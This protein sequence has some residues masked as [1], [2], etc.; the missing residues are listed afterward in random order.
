MS[1]IAR[2]S[3]AVANQIAA[4]EVVER[5]ASVVKELLEN[6]IDAG[7]RR[8]QVEIQAGGIDL[9]RITDDGCG[10][11]RDDAVLALER[12]ATSKIRA[13]EDLHS[14]T[15]LGFRGE[16]LPSIASVSR[17][18]LTTRPA[19]APEGTRV[20][21]EGGRP[22]EVM[23]VGAAP[24]TVIEVRDL[25]FN[26]PA[27]RKFLKTTAT[28]VSHIGDAVTRLALACPEVAFKLTSE[29]RT[30]LD[31]PPASPADP[32][33][34]LGRILGH[35]VAAQL[36][37]VLED[38]A[39][40]RVTVGGFVSS[41]AL[42]ER[43]ARNL[44]VFVNGRFVR[45]RTIQHAIQD[46]YRT[47]L[48]RGRQPV[49]VLAIG[50]DPARVDV[51]V[52][53]Q[54]TEVRFQDTGEV[55][56]AITASLHRTLVAEPWLGEVAG[57]EAPARRYVL[58]GGTAE[59]AAGFNEHRARIEDALRIVGRKT[60]GP[61]LG[62]AGAGATL[63]DAP[64]AE[65]WTGGHAP[66]GGGGVAEAGERSGFA[67]RDGR[68][69]GARTDVA[70][71]PVGWGG[72]FAARLKE[73]AEG[74]A[75]PRDHD[76]AGPDVGAT[77]GLE[78]LPRAGRP[79]GNGA[80][81]AGGPDGQL[82]SGVAG[83]RFGALEP[84]GQVMATYLVCQAPGRMVIVDQHAAHERI[85]F[86][87]LRKQAAAQAV[88]VQPLLVPLS[89]ELDA[90]RGAIAQ[91]AREQLA[92][93]GIELEPFG[94]H[95]WLVKSRPAAIGPADLQQLVLDLLDEVKEVGET[96]P[97]RERV[98]S[99]LSCAACHTV[100]RAGD[101]LT[102]AE[103]KALLAAMDEIDFGAHCPHGRPVF[104]EWT[105]RELGALFHRA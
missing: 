100:V 80:G 12:H 57:R 66:R 61:E 67:S 81:A 2:L 48:E 27:R 44:L 38:G 101:R 42:T 71:E 86:E 94:G 64:R 29:G 3:E 5:P 105:E 25:F 18:A 73:D 26:V 85:A 102:A 58:S 56:R 7:A 17:F 45:D 40:H 84:V 88:E 53:P 72:D 62:F 21:V 59:A 63:R 74:A 52:H 50:I 24:G 93:I 46:A 92:A 77:I 90:A 91:A 82:E 41:P 55:H 65:T 4:G 87:R 16:A 83:G 10:M 54:K 69:T 13:A 28:E 39:V 1:V 6:A 51:N 75:P 79:S 78:L 76:A 95:T 20:T 33:G 34:R 99:L 47:L 43:T 37:P 32:R 49:V 98:E 19:A 89:L 60:G 35:E 14:V 70:P 36:F 30:V 97:F 8:I 23:T 104:V 103:I 96:T 11:D 68:G 22:P 15:T 31:A 9:I